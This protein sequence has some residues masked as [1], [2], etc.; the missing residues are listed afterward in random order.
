M[1]KDEISRDLTI[2]IYDRD[3]ANAP[4]EHSQSLHSAMMWVARNAFEFVVGKPWTKSRIGDPPDLDYSD[5]ASHVVPVYLNVNGE[6]FA[7]VEDIELVERGKA[8]YS[9]AVQRAQIIVDALNKQVGDVEWRRLNLLYML[10]NDATFIPS[11]GVIVDE[12]K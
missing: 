10:M 11:H 2:A 6:R 8:D 1:M 5:F 9:L 7:F 4:A 3:D 12:E